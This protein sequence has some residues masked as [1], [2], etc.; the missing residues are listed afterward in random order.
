[1]SQSTS[2]N[3]LVPVQQNFYATIVDVDPQSACMDASAATGSFSSGSMAMDASKSH[4]PPRP[5][6]AK[7]P[8]PDPTTTGPTNKQQFDAIAKYLN[9][10]NER[11]TA[12]EKENNNL[13]AI[14]T[15]SGMKPI[16]GAQQID[17]TALGQMYQDQ[18]N[19][20]TQCMK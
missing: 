9:H 16:W 6:R 12:L 11:L 5:P 2:S 15:L 13:K 20:F 19:E 18:L 7:R 14:I 4:R 17:N 8:K 3:G 10:L 1:M